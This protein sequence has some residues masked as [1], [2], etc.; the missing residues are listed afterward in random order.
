MTA[1]WTSSSSTPARSSAPRI[2]IAPSSVASYPARAP[3]SLPKGVR[4]AETI[5]ERDIGKTLASEVEAGLEP[6]R[7]GRDEPHRRLDVVQRDDLARRVD[8]ARRERDQPGRDPGAARVRR[9]HV[10][11]RVAGRDIDGVGDPLRLGRLDEQLEDLRV[12]RRATVDDRAAAELGLAVDL[13]VAV[14]DVGGAGDVDRERD[15]R[16]EREDARARAPEVADLL[17]H[18]GH[19]GDVSDLQAAERLVAVARADVDVQVLELQLL[20]LLA[21]LEPLAA[22]APDHARYRAAAGHDLD[23]LAME[24]VRPL[25]ADGQEEDEAVVVD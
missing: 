13:R 21:G 23:A 25:P 16:L 22:L 15:L 7:E 10:R 4:T 18:G 8:V 1:Y 24:D 6:L 17:L 14:G 19:R 2:A 20:R 9:V 12:D 3:P 11:V 5:T